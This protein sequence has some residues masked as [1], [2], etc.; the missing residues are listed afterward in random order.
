MTSRLEG[1]VAL[2]TR[3]SGGIGEATARRLAEDGACVA[4]VARRRER[5]DALAAQ[6]E[7][8]GGTAMVV[9]AHIIDRAQAEAAVRQTVE[10][11]GRLDILVNND[12]LIMLLG[13]VVGADPHE[14]DRMIAVDTQG[15]L[16]TTHAAPA[17]AQGRRRRPR[18]VADI[19]SIAGR[20]AWNGYGVYNMTKFGVNGFT[21]RR[22][23]K[24][25]PSA[26]CALVSSSLVVSRLSSAH[27][28]RAQS[29]TRSTTSTR[30]PRPSHP[31]TSPKRDHLHGDPSPARF[32]RR[33]VDYAHRSSLT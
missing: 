6:I 2:V 20:V 1:T 14:W 18:Q 5:L 13:P 3:A 10:Q 4:L 12:G 15:L 19:S 24:R 17:P 32:D 8:T 11:F 7:Q 22:C 29:A 16:Y 21:E 27:T 33:T 30:Q 23:G 25:S 28:T 9:E 26:T 31:R